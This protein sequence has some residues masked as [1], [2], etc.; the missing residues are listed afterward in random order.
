MPPQAPAQQQASAPATP[1][2][3]PCAV[4][5]TPLA[6]PDIQLP[7][8]I[9]AERVTA[10]GVLLLAHIYG[11]LLRFFDAVYR[12]R[13]L[14][15]TDQ[16]CLDD[17]HRD[18]LNL[19]Y[20]WP[21]RHHRLD[22]VQLARLA[23]KVLG[24][25]HPDVPDE[26]RD[27]VIQRLLAGLLDSINSVCDPGCLRRKAPAA[28]RRLLESAVAAV[29]TRL[30]WS[31]TGLTTMQVRDL[32]VQLDT[33]TKILTELATLLPVPCRPGVAGPDIWGS[34]SYLVGDQLR[35]A[36]VDLFETAD[37]ARAWRVIF[38]W[39]DGYTG[40]LPSRKKVVCRAAALLRPPRR[41][42]AKDPVRLR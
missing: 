39:L 3:D 23:A 35:A 26:D 24:I 25:P 4:A 2:I 13:Q 12:A 36:D 8:L 19:L 11:T 20:C 42:R 17:Q 28:D 22:D 14:L 34:V 37:E 9:S 38:N 1:P 21:E 32:Q 31:M 40:G 41:D 6:L 15:D 5:A 33:A 29:Q 16:L 18:L 27:K 10:S 30:S 7:A